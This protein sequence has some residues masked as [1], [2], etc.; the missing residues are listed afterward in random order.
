VKEQI[1]AVDLQGEIAARYCRPEWH[2]EREV[3]LAGRRLDVVAFN[4]WGARSY[5]T[6]GFEIKVSRGDWMR[7]LTDFRKQDEWLA[8]V[9]EFFIVAPGGLVKP[10]ELPVGWGLLELRGSRMFTKAQPQPRRGTTLPREIVARFF[11]RLLAMRDSALQDSEQKDR[12]VT[13]QLRDELEAKVRKEM[14]EQGNPEIERHKEKADRYDALMRDLGLDSWWE[15][16][17]LR[18]A[19]Q[20]LKHDG[21]VMGLST[22]A[23]DLKHAAKRHAD[24]ADRIAAFADTLGSATAEG[25]PT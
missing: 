14:A 21:A 6:V 24:V 20:L 7:E 15:E 8:V 22:L 25:T 10:E 1:T 17:K 9:D 2:V 11:T 4:L 18:T 5:R 19:V 13:W 3:T 16:R 12:A 23:Q